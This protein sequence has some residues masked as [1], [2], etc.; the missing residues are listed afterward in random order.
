MTGLLLLRT[1][2]CLSPQQNAVHPIQHSIGYIGGLG[3]SGLQGAATHMA[4]ERM[5]AWGGT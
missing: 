5:S 2:Q 4:F 1:S 3:T